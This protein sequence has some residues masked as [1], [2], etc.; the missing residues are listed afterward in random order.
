MAILFASLFIAGCAVPTRA[1][2]SNQSEVS[3][4]RGRL[5]VRVESDQPQS[6]TA[7]FELT[8]NAQA[9]ELTLFTPLGSTAAALSWSSQTAL[10][11]SNGDV[12]YFDSLNALIKQAV[13]TEIP[14]VAL[15][16]W[17]AGDNMNVAGWSAD[18]SQQANGRITARRTQPAPLAE[19]RL[20]IEK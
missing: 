15:F 13:G 8:G 11:R 3:L 14:V 4:W 20:V 17:L 16:A 18:L 12:R 2:I 1:S 6:F 9:G 19:I 10:M 5:A 7:G